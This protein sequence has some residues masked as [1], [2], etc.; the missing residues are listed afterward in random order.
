VFSYHINN[1]GLPSP[2][3]F[4]GIS[5]FLWPWRQY[6]LDRPIKGFGTIRSRAENPHRLSFFYPERFASRHLI[7]F[8]F[9]ATHNHFVLDRGGKVFNRSA[10]VIKLPPSATL[11]DHLNLIGLL[12]TSTLAL[13]MRQVFHD[14]G[15]GGYGGGIAS[16]DWERFYEYDST[17]L[18]Q[19][20]LTIS[21][22][23]ARVVLASALDATAHDRAACLPS[24]LLAGDWTNAD[25]P[26]LLAVARERHRVLTHRLVALQEELDWLTYG[27]YGL[28]DTVE[29]VGPDD[30]EPLAPG[31][32]PFEILAARADEDAEPDEK[33]AWWSRHGHDKVT[34]IPEQYTAATRRRIQDRM[35]RIEA[36]PRLQ[37]L[38]SFPHKRRW[39]LPD[40]PAEEKKAA[41]SWLLDRLEDLFAPARE[42]RPA[43]ALAKP[44]P[45]RLEEIVAAWSRDERVDAAARVLTG[46]GDVDLTLVAEK[47][48]Q[49]HALPDNPYRLYSAEG[50]R[51]LDAWKA[52]WA[53]QDREDG[54]EQV[55]I[56]L[57]PQWKKEDFLK[58]DF[59][60]VRGKLNVPRER[61][62]RFGELTPPGYGWNGWRDRERALA[63]VE[64]YTLTES[65]PG[66]PLPQP[67]ATDPRRCGATLGLWESLPDVKRWGSAG[68][69][70]ELLALAQ[71][72]CQQP[73]CPCALVERWQAWQRGDLQVTP[74]VQP[75]EAPSLVSVRER[76][77]V[78]ALI[79]RIAGQ[80]SL[81]GGSEAT[82]GALRER[83]SGPLAHLEQVLDDLV[84]SG[85]LAVKGKGLK[86]VYSVARARGSSQ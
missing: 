3:T 32:R 38:E 33:S 39:Q 40:L 70:G 17:K 73:S 35:D 50:L 16:E 78:V 46:S 7:A 62:V 53:L 8:A 42:G 75:G 15:N 41:E 24:A 10:P 9:V 5:R 43:G 72:V 85:D 30:V 57:P 1:A 59:Y 64:A 21:D 14:K 79:E 51:K 84:A 48:L 65:D 13:W 76:A 49:G 69:H 31:H 66:D 86:R 63:Q 20:P 67:T 60:S 2:A 58:Q 26:M 55:E 47:L 18:Q 61:F 80:T 34:E 77:Q 27:S 56:P 44:R 12:N 36:D 54:G 29:T 71:E 81:L 74:A 45:Y 4:K 23:S 83:W 22:R 52:V 11:D 37:L 68:E 6:V 19:A 28:L 25:L 82:F